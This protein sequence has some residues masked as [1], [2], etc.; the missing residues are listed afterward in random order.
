MYSSIY[1]TFCLSIYLFVNLY[2]HLSV[3]VYLYLYLSP[4]FCPCPSLSLSIYLSS[5]PLSLFIAQ[6]PLLSLSLYLS[7]SYTHTQLYT[8]THTQSFHSLLSSHQIATVNT[9]APSPPR[10]ADIPT[11]VVV[12]LTLGRVDHID[13]LL[14]QLAVCCRCR[15][16]LCRFSNRVH[17]LIESLIEI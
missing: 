16:L 14:V 7:L 10:S 9:S 11:S 6:P 15:K 12:P 17:G 5:P 3:S 1:L 4:I 2:K 8:H 13:S